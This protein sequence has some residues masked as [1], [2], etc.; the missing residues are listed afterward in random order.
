M[1]DSRA[2]LVVCCVA[3][4]YGLGQ[5]LIK[6]EKH[7]DALG[8]FELACRINPAS[9][10][11]RCCCGL[12]LHKMGRLDEAARQLRVRGPCLYLV[13]AHDG[14]TRLQHASTDLW[15]NANG[16]LRTSLVLLPKHKHQVHRLLAE[17]ISPHLMLCVV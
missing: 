4:R 2:H 3:C 17:S 11:L 15:M 12:A 1:Y 5:I 13:L 6:Q 9:S 10:V 8:H 16:N 14:S 7:A